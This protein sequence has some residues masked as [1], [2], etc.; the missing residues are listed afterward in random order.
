M[1]SAAIKGISLLGSITVLPIPNE[2]EENG[3]EKMELDESVQKIYKK[4]IC[5]ILF[6]L[7]E[8]SHTKQKIREDSAS[9]LGY[10]AIGDV[11]YFVGKVLD[12][13]LGLI[14]MVNNFHIPYFK[15]KFQVKIKIS[16]E[17]SSITHC[18]GPSTSLCRSR[19]RRYQ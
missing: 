7:L 17:R 15:N 2:P 12:G 1:Q 9:C 18:N 11:K 6:D 10:L 14:K 4:D 8:S 3:D 16:D 19:N 5:K 13:F